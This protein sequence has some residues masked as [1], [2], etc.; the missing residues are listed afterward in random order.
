[1]TDP[2]QE[3][4]GDLPS[5]IDLPDDNSEH[6]EKSGASSDDPNQTLAPAI[7]STPQAATPAY[8]AFPSAARQREID[9]AV[10]KFSGNAQNMFVH[11]V[12]PVLQHRRDDLR[13]TGRSKRLH[14]KTA[15]QIWFLMSPEQSFFWTQ[16]VTELRLALKQGTLKVEDCLRDAGYSD[17]WYEYRRFAE[18]AV[19][20]Y[21]KQEVPEE[22]REEGKHWVKDENMVTDLTQDDIK[23]SMADQATEDDREEDE[24]VEDQT[25]FLHSATFPTGTG[26][27]MP[28]LDQ[29]LPQVDLEKAVLLCTTSITFAAGQT[30][31]S[32]LLDVLSDRFDYEPRMMYGNFAHAN[33][34]EIR[35][36]EGKQ[37]AAR[38]RQVA[39]LFDATGMVLF[40][41]YAYPHVW[42]RLRPPEVDQ[43]VASVVHE[44]WRRMSLPQ[45]GTWEIYG[46]RAKKLLG[47]G[48]VDGLDLLE[49][50]SMDPDV[51]DL[52]RITEE[53]L[54]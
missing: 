14:H 40:Y 37:Q 29:T 33:Y 27:D 5:S 7:I 16:K 36:L 9:R 32:Q 48:D 10:R 28:L 20:E 11:H 30:E 45:K 39:D 47:D 26:D 25:E 38:L 35:A 34:K 22:F 53:T 23:S 41:Y 31:S 18:M 15:A 19:A 49:L 17:E 13:A 21:T 8:K 44:H 3:S 43:T 46:R 1:M 50:D 24:Q 6:Q 12:E 4:G 2:P 54:G 51:F 52:H 42:K